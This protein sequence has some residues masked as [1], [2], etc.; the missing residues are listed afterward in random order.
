[1]NETNSNQA[2][3]SVRRRAFAWCFSRHALKTVFIVLAWAATGIALLYA[4]ENW[5]GRRAWNKYHQNLVARGE[6]LDFQ[7]FIPKRVP[8]DQNF[9]STPFVRAW[10]NRKLRSDALWE[11]QFSIIQGKVEKG[12]QEQG[13]RKLMDLGA[14]AKGFAS[15]FEIQ[16]NDLKTATEDRGKAGKEV[17]EEL[18]SMEPILR[19]LQQASTRPYSVYPVEYDLANPW[20]ILLPHL[21]HIRSACARLELRACAELAAGQNDRALESAK[22]LFYLVNSMQAEPFLIDFLVQGACLQMGTHVVWEG[23]VQHKWSDSQ[24]QE[25]QAILQKFD[26][27]EKLKSPLRCER[28]AVLHTVNILRAHSNYGFL[29]NFANAP[30]ARPQGPRGF[31]TRLVPGGWY[32]FEQ[33]NYCL[34]FDSQFGNIIGQSQKT[35]MPSQV[36]ASAARIE[37]LKLNSGPGAIWNHEACTVLMLAGL[38]NVIAKTVAGQVVAD[39]AYLACALERFRLSQGKYPEALPELAPQFASQM[40]MDVVGGQPYRYRRGAQ[41]GY[42]LYSLGWNEKDDNG[43]PGKTLFDEKAGDWVWECSTP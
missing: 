34:R 16:T 25:L 26:F 38:K 21:S 18:K 31:L 32:D 29:L 14:W 40:P 27:L 11:D 15:V 28:A 3:P 43:T 12:T 33:L 5:R 30:N 24:L 6:S 8:D 23:I 2:E 4:E 22:L 36:E 20:G 1:M 41:G 17:L 9:A 35:L 19:E 13:K 10:F 39:Q 7:S 37:G 42:V